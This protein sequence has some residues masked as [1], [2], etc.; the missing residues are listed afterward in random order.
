MLIVSVIGVGHVAGVGKEMRARGIAESSF[1]G[2]GQ[3]ESGRFSLLSLVKTILDP[4]TYLSSSL[5]A[6]SCF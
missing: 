6:G 5:A 3:E 2:T 4:R 1:S